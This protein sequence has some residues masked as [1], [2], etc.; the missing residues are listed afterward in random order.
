MKLVG[1]GAGIL[2]L[3]F[4]LIPFLA[5]VIMFVIAA[6]GWWGVPIIIAGAGLPI[7]LAVS[8]LE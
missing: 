7:L 4:V 2:L 5:L 1:L 3:A 8:N 6:F